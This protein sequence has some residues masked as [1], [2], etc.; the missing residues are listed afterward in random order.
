MYEEAA[1]AYREAVKLEP[2]KALYHRNLGD[3][4]QKKGDLDG[5]IAAYREAIKLK[6]DYPEAYWN[7]AHTLQRKG[8]SARPLPH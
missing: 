3:A 1:A 7:L 2:G 8:S 6:P 5:A 4:L